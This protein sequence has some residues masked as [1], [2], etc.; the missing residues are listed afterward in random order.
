V[1]N[2]HERGVVAA[3]AARGLGERR[4]DTAVWTK[5]EATQLVRS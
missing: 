2:T 5:L 4:E 3:I 1:T